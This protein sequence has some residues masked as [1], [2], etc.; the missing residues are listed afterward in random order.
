[1]GATTYTKG[2]GESAWGYNGFG[3][4]APAY[5]VDGVSA[6]SAVG[7]VAL[8]YDANIGVTGVAGVGAVNSVVI[9]VDDA[10]IP[11]GAQG[12]GLV[13]NVRIGV[14]TNVNDTQ[15]PDWTSIND[16]QSPAWGDVNKAA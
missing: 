15:T 10:V 13:G 6:T 11:T 16:T 9:S 7:A 12:L 1:M 8:V 5:T 3:G 14:W 2:W 4:I